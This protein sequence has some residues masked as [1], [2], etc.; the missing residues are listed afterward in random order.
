MRLT[1]TVITDELRR[2]G[3]NVHVQCRLSAKQY[4]PVSV[5]C[6]VTSGVIIMLW[7]NLL[8]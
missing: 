5:R 6:K 3:H 1:L 4:W 8:A 7:E 2:L